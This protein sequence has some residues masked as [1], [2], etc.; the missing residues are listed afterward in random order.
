MCGLYFDLLYEVWYFRAAIDNR[1][2]R[3][4]GMIDGYVHDK[5]GQVFDVRNPDYGAAG[6]GTT[7]DTAAI[8][9]AI[10]AAEA[11]RGTVFV[12]PGTY[13]ITGANNPQSGGGPLRLAGP[14]GLTGAGGNP[15]S[16]GAAT[17]FLCG[18]SSA[19]IVAGG[20]GTYRGFCVDGDSTATTPLQNGT[21][22]GGAATAACSYSTFVDVWVTGSAGNGWTIL[23][24]QSNSYYDCGSV[25]SADDGLY[26]DGGAGGL[27]FWGFVESGSGQYG[28]HADDDVS[29]GTGT[30]DDRTEQ[31][32]FYGGS[33]SSSSGDAT[34][35]SKV[36]LRSAYDWKLLDMAIA[37]DN[38]SGPTVD[39]D[40]SAG[41]TLD[42]S[43]C[44]ISATPTGQQPGL[45]CIEVG[46][47]PP[48]GADPLPFLRTDKVRFTDGDTSVYIAAAGAYTYPAL[49]WIYDGTANGPA[50][51]SGLDAAALLRGR[52]GDWVSV[53]VSTS[54]WGGTAKYRVDELGRVELQGTLTTSGGGGSIFTLPTGYRPAAAAQFP[55]AVANGAASVSVAANGVV[56]STYSGTANLYLDGIRFPV[57]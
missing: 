17:V 31:V 12:P 16:S 36:Y 26:V 40:Q 7:D 29:G 10:A 3:G 57:D 35:V 13:L 5:G 50:A 44:R 6:D 21:L 19:G 43:R 46:G 37:G 56:A 33:L 55:V 54:P 8:A 2:V 15:G 48:G 1:G 39:L 14:G 49:D 18:D 11:V 38:L 51:A 25:D 23:G 28:V 47:T 52:T 30:R 42:F 45:A 32:R 41:D 24:C 20:P 27:A 34:G 4:R 22:S 53:P 9:A